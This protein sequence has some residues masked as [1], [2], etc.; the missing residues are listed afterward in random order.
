V[1]NVCPLYASSILIFLDLKER[2]IAISSAL[3]KAAYIIGD[4]P[5]LIKVFILAPKS[6][7][8]SIAH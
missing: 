8:N 4:I 2:Y 6:Q 3:V 1:N 5:L 7:N